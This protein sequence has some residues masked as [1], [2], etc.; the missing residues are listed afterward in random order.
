VASLLR[1]GLVYAGMSL[2]LLPAQ[3][4]A[5]TRAGARGLLCLHSAMDPA[6]FGAPWP[7]GLPMQIHVMENDELGDVDVA[8]QVVAAVDGAELFLYPGDRHL[9]TD[10][11]FSDY[12]AEAAALVRERLVGFLAALV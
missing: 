1:P 8:R 6:E 10:R 7:P 12:D 4:L 9:F 3:E 5:Q 2:G 11:S